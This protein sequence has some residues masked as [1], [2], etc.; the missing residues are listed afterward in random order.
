MKICLI[1]AMLYQLSYQA[2]WE[3]A[4][5]VPEE[6]RVNYVWVQLVISQPLSAAQ[7]HNT[8]GNRLVIP[9]IAKNSTLSMNSGTLSLSYQ[10]FA[11]FEEH[12]SR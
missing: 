5:K 11:L 12:Q 4:S 10:V 1:V 3:L 6:G 7:R 9:R 2:N 8:L